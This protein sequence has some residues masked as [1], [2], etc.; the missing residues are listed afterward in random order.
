MQVYA[1]QRESIEEVVVGKVTRARN[2]ESQYLPALDSDGKTTTEYIAS[3]RKATKPKFTLSA[4]QRDARDAKNLLPSSAE[5]DNS[6]DA[7]F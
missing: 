7:P 5:S 1:V 2:I 3:C 4:R 6:H